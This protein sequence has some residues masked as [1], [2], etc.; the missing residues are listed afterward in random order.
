MLRAAAA[1][2]WVR[3]RVGGGGAAAAARRLR[4]ARA[5]TP[6]RQPMWCHSIIGTGSCVKKS[7]NRNAAK[8]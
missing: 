1:V 7:Q 6:R 5:R 2:A 3:E 4:F 8:M